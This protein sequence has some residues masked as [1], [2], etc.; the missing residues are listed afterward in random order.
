MT[1]TESL[2]ASDAIHQLFTEARTANAFTDE[3]VTDD[4]AQTIFDVVKWA[5]T[6]MNQQALRVLVIRS[7][8]QRAKLVEAMMRATSPRPWPLP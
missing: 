7:Q 5:P 8:D 2:L 3:P 4:E 1:T 6:A